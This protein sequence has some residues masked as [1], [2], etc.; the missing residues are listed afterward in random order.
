LGNSHPVSQGCRSSADFHTQSTS[1]C[2]QQVVQC[3]Y[4]ARIAKAACLAAYLQIPPHRETHIKYRY[5]R[6]S[7]IIKFIL[8]DICSTYEPR[9]SN[10]SE[11]RRNFGSFWLYNSQNH[12][13]CLLG[14]LYRLHTSSYD[15]RYSPHTILRRPSVS[16]HATRVKYANDIHLQM[17]SQCHPSGR[18]HQYE[19]LECP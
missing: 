2:I 18:T 3:L 10:A 15:G 17:A 14:D 4:R 19:L 16:P 9:K 11:Q 12:V 5:V 8:N 6:H 7:N 13:S 1:L